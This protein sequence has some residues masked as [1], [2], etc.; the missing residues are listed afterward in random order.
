MAEDLHHCC[1]GIDGV[2]CEYI[3]KHY[4]FNMMQDMVNDPE[5]LLKELAEGACCIYFAY[6]VTSSTSLGFTGASEAPVGG[7]CSGV[8]FF[9][10]GWARAESME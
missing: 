1:Y 3:F 6:I 2:P 9:R 10:K 5:N 4:T 7:F 8:C